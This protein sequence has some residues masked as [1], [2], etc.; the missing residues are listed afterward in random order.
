V[1]EKISMKLLDVL[2]LSPRLRRIALVLLLLA[3]L[4]FLLICAAAVGYWGG[5]N[6][7][8]EKVNEKIVQPALARFETPPVEEVVTWETINTHFFPLQIARFNLSPDANPAVWALEEIDGDILYVTRLGEFGYLD[9]QNSLHRIEGLHVPMG[10]E[11]LTQ[12]ELFQDPIF[13]LSEFRT[14]DLLSIPAGANLYDLYVSHHRYRNGC[15]E[16]VVSHTQLAKDDTGVHAASGAWDEI[17]FTDPCIPVKSIGMRLAGHEGG[18]RLARLNEDTLLLS[19]G[20]HQF[21]G[22]DGPYQVGQDDKNDLSKIIEISLKDGS[23]SFYARGF[24]NPQGLL[25]ASDGRVWETE[26]GPRGGD[27][28]NLI[29]PGKNYGWP[30]ATYGTNYGSVPWPFNPH[31]GKQVGFEHPRFSFVPAIGISNIIEPNEEE[32]PEWDEHLVVA[33]L[34]GKSLFALKTEGDEITYS[35]QVLLG[36]RLRDLISLS[37]GRIAVLTDSGQLILVR[38]GDKHMDDAGSFT[39]SNLSER[40]RLQP[41]ESIP[42]S[43]EVVGTRLFFYHCGTCHTTDGKTLAGPPLN[44]VLGRRIGSVEGYPYSAALQN[45]KGR[46]TPSRLRKLL[47]H[48]GAA[49]DESAMPTVHLYKDEFQA[50]V[51][52]LRTTEA[53]PEQE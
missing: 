48:D 36:E 9:Q 1:L 22:V 32:F 16:V 2:P 37:D 26:H 4:G 25:V 31:P 33:S 35:E 13:Q 23:H 43:I 18:G 42:A 21:D 24:R 44:G 19:I 20:A 11:A 5:K 28:V 46:W 17:F 29:Q 40:P 12:S 7:T 34:W 6:N 45:A 15:F 49:F 39:V 51:A 47:N 50:L 30:I 38:N 8:L 53:E 41:A 27:E 14:F 10:L 3:G 52:Y